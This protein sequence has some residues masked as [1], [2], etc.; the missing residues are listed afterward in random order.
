MKLILRFVVVLVSLP[1]AWVVAGWS[2]RLTLS[3]PL[4]SGGYEGTPATLVV[5]PVV[6][7][8]TFVLSVIVGNVAI[9]RYFRGV[10]R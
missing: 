8:V 4:P 7:L 9:S 10:S 6:L 1:L 2:S 3:G 5:V